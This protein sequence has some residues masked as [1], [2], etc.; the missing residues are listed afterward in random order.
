MIVQRDASAAIA[1]EIKPLLKRRPSPGRAACIETDGREDGGRGRRGA[2][3]QGC[4]EDTEGQDTEGHVTAAR[5]SVPGTLRRL[6]ATNFGVC[7][8]HDAKPPG[9]NSQ[10]CTGCSPNLGPW[11]RGQDSVLREASL[12]GEPRKW[13]W[14]DAGVTGEPLRGP[15]C[16][17]CTPVASCHSGTAVSWPCGRGLRITWGEGVCPT[18]DLCRPVRSGGPHVGLRGV[19]RS[20]RGAQLCSGNRGQSLSPD[21]VSYLPNMTMYL[22][23]R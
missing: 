3:V 15:P 11:M 17:G 13:G 14:G 12:G 9:I 18:G 23:M 21:P 1:V 8:Q 4:G 16:G 5:N 2:S 22:D 20:E 19:Q 7:N 10:M 6:C